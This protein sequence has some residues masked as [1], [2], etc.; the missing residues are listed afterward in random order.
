MLRLLSGSGFVD[1]KVTHR[2][3][4][5]TLDGVGLCDADELRANWCERNAR[6]RAVAFPVGHRLAPL[7][8]VQRYLDTIPARVGQGRGSTRR[9]CGCAGTTPSASTP[10]PCRGGGRIELDLGE[11]RRQRQ[12]ELEP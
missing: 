8:A 9:S 4:R 1:P 6:M 10:A 11:H 12:L 5:T 7:R 3:V 2:P